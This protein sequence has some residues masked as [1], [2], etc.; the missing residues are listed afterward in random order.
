MISVF[1]KRR[2]RLGLEVRHDVF[3]NTQQATD[4]TVAA[5]SPMNQGRL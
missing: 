4:H 3:E 1:A 5:I 2:R